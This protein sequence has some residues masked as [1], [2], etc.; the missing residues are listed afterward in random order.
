MNHY[1][2][3]GIFLLLICLGCNQ[4]K[5]AT[6]KEVTGFVKSA[7]DSIQVVPG[8]A[9]AIVDSTGVVMT[10]GFGFSDL[11]NDIKVTEETNFYIASTTKPFVGLLGAILHY[12][13]LLDLDKKIV[14]YKP[15]KNFG[16]KD[17]FENVTI[18]DLLSHQSGIDN[19]YLSFR[20]AYTGSYTNE[21]IL[22]IIEEETHYREEGKEFEYTNFGYYLFSVLLQEEFG[23]KWQDLLDE[24]VFA[25]LNMPDA[26]GYISENR[27]SLWAQ[28]YYGTRPS[29]LKKASTLKTDAT[30]HAAGG[31]VMNAKDVANFMRFMINNG[32]L[33]GEQVYPEQ[34][35]LNNY[36]KEVSTGDDIPVFNAH[37]YG[38][39]WLL[40]TVKGQT[41]VNHQGG[42]IG[43]K[44]SITF[45][46][47]KK[48]GVAVFTNHQEMGRTLANTISDYVYELYLGENNDLNSY[49]ENLFKDIRERLLKAQKRENDEIEKWGSPDW[50]L[51]LPKEAYPGSFYNKNDGTVNIEYV[52]DKFEISN[53]N[54]FCMGEPYFDK[55]CFK[56]ELISTSRKTICF[57]IENGEVTGIDFRDKVFEKIKD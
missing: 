39:G 43:Y 25:P 8:V 47:E 41:M 5:Q 44:S 52:N 35:V 31:L 56:V 1:K 6:I 17:V 36:S 42:Y 19:P 27:P 54:L 55:D 40:G 34:V 13:G 3:L 38:L 53:G 51:T 30:M 23:A 26:S 28:P 20:L 50:N 7:M 33:D 22:R 15:F 14:D 21:D 24:K 49:G 10:K 2:L 11:E 46:P 9:V 32:Y 57:I 48:L 45:F 4:D 18:R 29:T 12:E 37:G 16:R